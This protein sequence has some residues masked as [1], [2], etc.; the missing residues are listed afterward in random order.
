MTFNWPWALLSLL[1]V[2]LIF[3]IAWVLRRRRKR[4][5]VR[6]TSLAVVRAAVPGR[7]S[8]LRFVPVSLLVLGLLV[9]SVGAARPQ[10]TVPVSSNSTTIM[11]A[12]DVS[13]SMCSTD[14]APNRITVAE[15][16]AIDFIQNNKTGAKI[17]LVAFAGVA[18]LR[19]P[20]TTDADSLVSAIKG[21]STARGTAI[22]AAILTSI[23]GIAAVDP[24]VSGTAVDVTSPA[25]AYAADVIVVLTDGANTQGVD[26]QTAAAQAALRG[27][28]VYTIG[29]GTTTPTRMACTGAQ[30]ESW[31]G[32]GGGG[33]FG[34][35]GFGGGGR[36]GGGNPLVID[37]QA[38]QDVAKTTG[39][40]YYRA[41]D[42]T[43]LSDA[44]GDLP[45]HV[46]VATKKQDIAAWFAG[47]GGLLLVLAVG[48][49]VWLGRVRTA[50]PAR[51]GGR[52][53]GRL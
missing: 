47:I 24:A 2:P 1:V 42:A 29:F 41:V 39:G 30:V 35:G 27:L 38:L 10:A 25:P 13:G 15:N 3:G 4:A 49:S 40:Q 23:D 51:F 12:L 31:Y 28:R 20:P 7:S 8:W 18:A 36:E 11:L 48:A 19:V 32:G 34:G 44:L 6:V 5:V 16:A 53:Q 33:G 45:N 9:L 46:T 21:L 37:E 26:P 14:V 43:Q 17:G 22:G 52:V 50:R